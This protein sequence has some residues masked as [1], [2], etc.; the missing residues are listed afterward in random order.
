VHELRAQLD[1]E[2]EPRD[3]PRVHAA[4]EPGARLENDDTP[5]RIMEGACRSEASDTAADDDDV[6]GRRRR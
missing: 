4:A 3:T 6:S 2:R 5:V 1:R